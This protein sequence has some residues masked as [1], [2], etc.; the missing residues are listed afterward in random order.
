M[1]ED[2]DPHWAAYGFVARTDV[3]PGYYVEVKDSFTAQT[4]YFETFH[5]VVERAKRPRPRKCGGFSVPSAQ[6]PKR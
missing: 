1:S 6:R 3:P 5:G 4:F 2:D